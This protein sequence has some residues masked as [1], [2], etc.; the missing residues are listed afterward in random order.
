MTPA[1]RRQGQERAALVRS[2]V[3]IAP[4]ADSTLEVLNYGSRLQHGTSS[5]PIWIKCSEDCLDAKGPSTQVSIGVQLRTFLAAV[6]PESTVKCKHENEHPTSCCLRAA[7]TP[8]LRLCHPTSPRWAAAVERHGLGMPRCPPGDGD[9][10]RC[11][12]KFWAVPD[13]QTWVST[14]FL[15]V[16]S[17]TPFALSLPCRSALFP[18]AAFALSAH[19]GLDAFVCPRS[20]GHL[21]VRIPKQATYGHFAR[22]LIVPPTTACL[23][24]VTLCVYVREESRIVRS[25]HAVSLAR[26]TRYAQ[27]YTAPDRLLVRFDPTRH[28]LRLAFSF[29]VARPVLCTASFDPCYLP[30]PPHSHQDRSGPDIVH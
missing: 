26:S 23:T 16:L 17:P 18:A 19:P 10:I 25:A 6:L 1:W 27:P 21:L 4:G 24:P 29:A 3:C 5:A 11:L 22:P 7:E 12:V 2:R 30:R 15:R 13:R 8:S 28:K 14:R 20:A 9:K